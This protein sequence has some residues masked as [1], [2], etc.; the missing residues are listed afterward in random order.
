M[1]KA[2][3]RIQLYTYKLIVRINHL[4]QDVNVPLSALRDQI[5][6]HCNNLVYR[7]KI[8]VY[9]ILTLQV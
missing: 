9:I 5:R 8:N 3:L 2:V 7:L 4:S 6:S 1:F